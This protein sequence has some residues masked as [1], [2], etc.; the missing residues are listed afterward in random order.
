MAVKK[1][2]N[3]TDERTRTV[4]LR[5]AQ[6]CEQGWCQGAG[7]RNATGKPINPSS[8]KAVCFCAGSAIWKAAWEIGQDYRDTQDLIFRGYHTFERLIRTKFIFLWN[9]A[10]GRSQ[11]GVVATLRAAA[12]L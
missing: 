12:G 3:T 5:A 4:L 11:E 2:P 7:A 10:P 8:D 9:D 6:I 1:K